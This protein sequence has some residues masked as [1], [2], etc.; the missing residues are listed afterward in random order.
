M[1]DADFLDPF[2]GLLDELV[3]PS[4]VRRIER[5][6]EWASVWV[7]V[8]QSG[9]LDVMVPEASGGSGLPLSLAGTLMQAVAARSVPLPVAETMVA[10]ALLAE[11]GIDPPDGPIAIATLYGGRANAVPSALVAE[12]LLMGSANGATLVRADAVSITPTGMAHGL[13][14][15][16]RIDDDP[17]GPTIAAPDHALLRAGAVVRAAL[18]AGACDRMLGMTIAHANDRVQFGKPIGR[19]Q[20]IQQQI[21]CMAE[22]TVCARMA[23]QIGCAGRLPPTL[24][25]AAT[26]KQVGSVAAADVA[27]IAHAVHGAIGIS[28]EFDLHLLSRR[29]H[30][31][32]LADGGATFWADRLGQARAGQANISTI[33]FVREHVGHTEAA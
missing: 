4:V 28:E 6:G 20:A 15:H 23:A 25:N 1:D 10:R 21:A 26:A 27:S 12:H 33:D 22:L 7:E 19:Q 29:L 14:G 32:R 13:A 8:H 11:G 9:F 30:E 3:P 24:A 16:L 17:V 5:G 31:W 2:C 18:I